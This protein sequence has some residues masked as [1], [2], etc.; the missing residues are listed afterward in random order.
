[1]MCAKENENADITRKK[2]IRNVA[3]RQPNYGGCIVRQLARS[4]VL[5]SHSDDGER[6]ERIEGYST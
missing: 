2:G 6:E 4:L 3:R 1:M 5:L